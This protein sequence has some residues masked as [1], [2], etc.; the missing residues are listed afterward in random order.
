MATLYQYPTPVIE[1]SLVAGG[2]LTPNTTYY[3]GAYFSGQYLGHSPLSQQYSITTDTTN[4]TINVKIKWWNGSSWDYN[5]PVTSFY[6]ANNT[7]FNIIWNTTDMTDGA[8]NWVFSSTYATCYILSV[9]SATYNVN[10]S[11]NPTVN[12][13]NAYYTYIPERWGYGM[14]SGSALSLMGWSL[15]QGQPIVYATSKSDTWANMVTAI[16]SSASFT[17]YFFT[18]QANITLIAYLGI[19]SSY[20]NTWNDLD[21]TLYFS[22]I[23]AP[24]ATL[25]RCVINSLT[26]LQTLGKIGNTVQIV[27]N[28]NTVR[29]T[30]YRPTILVSGLDNSITSFGG[31]LYLGPNDNSQ[32]KFINTFILTNGFNNNNNMSWYNTFLYDQILS[33]NETHSNIYQNIV[34]ATM[35]WA[36]DWV[37]INSFNNTTATLTIIDYS[38]DTDRATSEGINY[39]LLKRPRIYWQIAAGT[40]YVPKTLE[41]KDTIN[42]YLVDNNRAPISNA[43]VNIVNGFETVS[44]TTDANGFLSKVIKTRTAVQDPAITSGSTYQTIWTDYTKITITISKTGYETYTDIIDTLVNKSLQITLKP[45]VPTRQTI[46]GKLLLANQAELGSSSKLLEI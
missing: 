6:S 3:F 9:N 33:A 32:R 26:Y 2:S 41:L 22:S 34:S 25:N 14:T 44:G 18:T 46:E 43:T 8:G 27:G 23:I 39:S 13:T 45:I 40:S 42:L 29:S 12:G 17:N 24:N 7:Y 21:L 10:Y 19:Y 4:L 11:T 15:T 35:A 16:K 20:T 36:Y 38:I 30:V 5:R 37:F 1:L 28:N 31:Q